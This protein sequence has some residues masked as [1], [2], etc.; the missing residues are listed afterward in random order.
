MTNSGG[1]GDAD[2]PLN[3]MMSGMASGD[4]A[5][6]WAFHETFEGRLRGVVLRHL[7]SMGRHDVAA[8]RARVAELVVDASMVI[9][10]RASGWH[11]GAA[12]P[13]NWAGL[14]IRSQIAAELG[15]RTTEFSDTDGGDMNNGEV[16]ARP[17]AVVDPAVDSLT[18]LAERFPPV[19]L[20]RDAFESVGSLR[21]QQIA[22][23]FRVQKIEGDPS[24]AHT[25]AAEFG[26][27]PVNAR[28]IHQRHW[29]RVQTVVLADERY[30]SLRGLDWFAA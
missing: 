9:F 19:R 2:D 15:H 24:P 29:D 23:L 10:D 22:W 25:V 20:L 3:Q 8:D 4:L 27:T 12:M 5:W 30:S 14:A 17:R 28:K 7:R 16:S 1:N 6:L 11:R 26:I 18:R 13:W 21:N